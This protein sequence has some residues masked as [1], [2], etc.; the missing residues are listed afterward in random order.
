MKIGYEE[1]GIRNGKRGIFA[2]NQTT[3]EVYVE[4]DASSKQG[5]F[6]ILLP[7]VQIGKL[8]T[9]ENAILMNSYAN[10]VRA[11]TVDVVI[12]S[13]KKYQYQGAMGATGI[14]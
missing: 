8:R 5:Q 14:K 4:V 1:L 9:Y 12:N 10:S 11:H 6:D 13:T 7:G 2:T 3:R